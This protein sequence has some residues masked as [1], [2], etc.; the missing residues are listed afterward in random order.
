MYYIY[1][2]CIIAFATFLLAAATASLACE[3]PSA[4]I[5][6]AKQPEQGMEFARGCSSPE[7]LRP[8]RMH[9]FNKRVASGDLP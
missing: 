7:V 9:A 8:Q 2:L 1:I 4:G 6:E 5:T 3:F